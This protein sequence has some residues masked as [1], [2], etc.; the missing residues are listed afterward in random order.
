MNKQPYTLI[1]VLDKRD[2]SVRKICFYDRSEALD[3]IKDCCNRVTDV[4]VL[5]KTYDDKQRFYY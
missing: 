4:I 3:Y 5:I 2:N 1:R